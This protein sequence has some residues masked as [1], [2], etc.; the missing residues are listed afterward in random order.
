MWIVAAAWTKKKE[1]RLPLCCEIFR[2]CLL[3]YL[4][5][6]YPQPFAASLPPFLRSFLI[7]PEKVPTEGCSGN[8]FFLLPHLDGFQWLTARTSRGSLGRC[9]ATPSRAVVVRGWL[10]G[11]ARLMTEFRGRERLTCATYLSPAEAESG[12][13]SHRYL[14]T[15]LIIWL[16][17]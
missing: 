12:G 13:G 3:L 1:V 16:L 11:A 5:C 8:F 15:F 2:W 10:T 17:W 4:I 7:K 14:I 6:C 9:E